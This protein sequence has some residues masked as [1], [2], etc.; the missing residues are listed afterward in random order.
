MVEIIDCATKNDYNESLTHEFEI[1][2]V[3]RRPIEDMDY[4]LR[5]LNNT[6]PDIM[7]QVIDY[8]L[9]WTQSISSKN[10]T[11][12]NLF[13]VEAEVLQG[14][15]ELLSSYKIA[16]LELLNFSK[17]QDKILDGK[18]VILFKDYLK[19]YLF[20][21][22]RMAT[23]LTTVLSRDAALQFYKDFI[24]NY[25]RERKDSYATEI[26]DPEKE[27]EQMKK[28]PQATHDTILFLL[29]K[30]MIVSKVTRCM[31]HELLSQFNDAEIAYAV[32][33]H[34]D[35]T[36]ATCSN[37]NLVLT[38]NKTLMQG[39]E[40]CDFCWHDKRFDNELKH[41][42]MEFWEKVSLDC[43]KSG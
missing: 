29:E 18:V 1:D 14:Y 4:F 19:S 20:P 24:D 16:I 33:C 3:L 39:D 21:V 23:S 5:Y 17:Y 37:E 8:L 27:F 40:Y 10:T 31:W 30:G 32:A 11:P 7:E 36:V 22:Y 13:E 35:F 41:P 43:G 6:A 25:V 42:D 38:R 15:P 26:E 12:Q 34:V 28:N 9:K 2:K